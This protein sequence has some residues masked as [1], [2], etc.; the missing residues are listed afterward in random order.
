VKNFLIII[1]LA[2]L[3]FELLSCKK[4]ASVSI[5]GKWN[6][7]NDSITSGIGPGIQDQN[8]IGLQ[9]DY[10]DFRADG[11]VYT[12]EGTQLDTLSYAIYP[13]NKI[14]IA[15]FGWSG[16][17]SDILKLTSHYATIHAPNNNNPGGYYERTL[18]LVR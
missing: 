18:N 10:F 14:T 1:F 6:V 17:M 4:D 13:G 7:I 5:A 12:R 9:D 3:F 16:T 11:N 8:Y 2:S 15:S